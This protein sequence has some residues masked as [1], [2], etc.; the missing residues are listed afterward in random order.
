VQHQEGG[1]VQALF[2]KPGQVVRRGDALLLVADLRS[3]AALALLRSQHE[4]ERLRAARAGA[5][6]A[7]AGAVAWPAD[8]AA[9]S[10]ALARERQLFE[11]RR[12][13]L[14]EQLAAQSVQLGEARAREAA[15]RSQLDAAD[16]AAALAREELELNRTL[17]AE[18]FIQK[19]RLMSFERG[20]AELDGR[21][22]AIRSQLAEA[23]GQAAA[24]AQA[25]A[26]ARSAYQQRAADEQR[27]A[28]ARL[29]ELEERLRPGTDLA[30]RQTVRAPVDGTVMALRVSAVGVAVGPREPL[31]EIAPSGEGLVIDV[32]IDPHDIDQVRVGGA[33][34]VR[35][36]AFDAR[37]TPLLAATVRSLSPDALTDAASQR[38]SYRAQIEVAPAELARHRELHLQAGMPAEVFISTAPRSLFDTLLEPLGLAAR[39]GLREP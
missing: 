18:G 32:P 11:A 38:S 30:A 2:V 13:A 6:L 14:D 19:T 31:L 8:A 1:I 5:E 36:S 25:Q 24:Q 33:A 17:V 27:D 34:E 39:R 20:V 3:D 26:Q 7:G 12:R 4:A 16:R 37:R 22:A 21:S 29:R 23:R 9:D 35:L 10:D 28:G 15:L